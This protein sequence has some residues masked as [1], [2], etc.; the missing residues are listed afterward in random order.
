MNSTERAFSEKTSSLIGKDAKVIVAF[1][2]GCDSL[3][4]LALCRNTMD[5]KDITAVY[6]NHRLREKGELEAEIRL[7]RENCRTLGI[8]LIIR[9]LDE[10]G[11]EALA[12]QRGGGTEEAARILRY[13]ILEE[14][15]HRAG[16]IW[17]LTAHHLQD[18]AETILM[19]IRS[20]SPST[21]LTGI[22]EKD[23]A[24]HLARLLLQSTREEL[25]RYN[26]E[27]NLQWSTDSTN[28][29][30]RYS[31]NAVRN[32]LMPA[33]RDIWSGAEQA[34]TELGKEAEKL[35]GSQNTQPTNPYG[36]AALTDKTTSERMAVL[37]SLWDSVFTDRELP[38]T[39]MSR[40]LDAI[41]E[42]EE[43][44]RDSTVGAG[45][46]IFTLYHGKLYL[47]DPE[48]DRTYSTFCISIDPGTPQ[49][50]T[51]PGGLVF[52][53]HEQAE[54]HAKQVKAD[55]EK[56][57][58]LD[59]SLFNG[60]TI[61]R[62]AREG[63]RIK[64]KGGWKTLGRLLQDMGIPAVLRCRIP[65]LEDRDGICAVFGS[66]YGGRDRIAVKF[67]SSLARIG[68]PLYIVSK[69]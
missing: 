45:G 57:L 19:R 35:N 59:N 26:N 37:F 2:G 3:A 7:N 36:I 46:G 21:T 67:R 4:L 56:L 60:E 54:G 22:R 23:D 18:Q 58:R 40:V 53:T 24:R 38:M 29:D 66:C 27:N 43:N 48:E 50:K 51:L 8:N 33:I 47:T 31:R 39:L 5:P 52:R 41:S 1:S 68:F 69:G 13:R 25:E 49:E 10:G 61:L 14:E 9:E 65:V 34:L 64:V 32:D 20:G 6:V 11:V 17:I 15:R 55:E 63:D 44:G 42:Y 30:A 16:A 62:F 12:A 28:T